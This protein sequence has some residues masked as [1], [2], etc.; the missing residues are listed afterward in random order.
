MNTIADITLS[1][2]SA[3]NYFGFSVSSAG[4]VNGDGYS[5]VIVGAFAYSNKGRAYIFLGGAG[6][7]NSADVIMTG[8]TASY[9]GY[10]E[11]THIIP[12]Q[13]GRIYFTEV[14]V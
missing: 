8:V 9:F 14:Q 3:M 13:E 7:N 6:M 5:D 11:Q 1:G 4:D 12:K 10:S 2:E